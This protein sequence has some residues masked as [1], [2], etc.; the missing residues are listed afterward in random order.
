MLFIST[1]CG[2]GGG[3]LAD[4]RQQMYELIRL[5]LATPLKNRTP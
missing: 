1:T 5:S 4:S 3:V 2:S